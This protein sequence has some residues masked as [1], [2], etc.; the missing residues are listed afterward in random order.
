MSLFAVGSEFYYLSAV[1]IFCS[2]SC[3]VYLTSLLLVL[4]VNVSSPRLLLFVITILTV[5]E[6]VCDGRFYSWWKPSCAHIH[7]QCQQLYVSPLRAGHLN[8]SDSQSYFDFVY[9]FVGEKKSDVRFDDRSVCKSFLLGCCPN[10]VLSATVCIVFSGGTSVEHN[11]INCDN[12]KLALCG[13]DGNSC[14]PNSSKF[15]VTWH[16]N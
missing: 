14:E 10:D 15:K 2:L 12:W 1:L 4:S 13:T 8:R 3:Y 5:I 16:K 9:L 6:L 7:I 11:H